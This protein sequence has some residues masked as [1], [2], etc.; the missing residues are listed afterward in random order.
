MRTRPDRRPNRKND[1]KVLMA[2]ESTKS[3]ADTDS[4]SSS[5]SSS[6]SSDSEQEEV[7]CLMADQASDDEN[8]P[9]LNDNGKAG[10]GFS[11]PENS[12]PSWLKNK[13]DK[14]KAKAGRKP[15]VPNQP[16]RSSMKVVSHRFTQ[17][18]VMCSGGTVDNQSREACCVGNIPVAVFLIHSPTTMAS[19][20]ISSS[21]HVDFES[22]FGFDDAMV[23][24]F[25]TLI[26]TG[27]KNFLGCPA[28]FYEAALTEFFTNGSVRDGLVVSTVNGVTVEISE[29]VFA[30]AFELLI[31]G[32]TD[33]SDVPKNLASKTT[34]P[35]LS[36]V[37]A[38]ISPLFDDLKTYLSQRMDTANSDI[39][40]IL[41]TVERGVQDTLGQQNDYFRGLI[42]SARQDAQTQDNIQTLRFNEFCKNILAQNASIFTG[43]ADVRKE[44][45]EINAKVDIMATNLEIVKKDVEASKEALSHQL[46]EF[47]AQAQANH[48]ILHAPLSEI[49]A[50]INRG[51][52]NKKGESSSS[53]GPQPPPPPVDQIRG[54]GANVSIPDFA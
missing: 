7:H 26:T 39:L 38:D 1:R 23:Q 14:D 2:E 15:F 16:W 22:V 25:E 37:P 33:L 50:Y 32:L 40:S 35:T 42:Q 27:L 36:D 28:V 43:L 19:S 34:T 41:H 54:T 30:E 17:L 18:Q 51:G 20:L 53:R 3:W 49:V 31:D 9:K 45:Q 48:N 11:K 52:D 13:L 21:H 8:S 24:M 44:V 29:K 47:Q 4:D 5:S 6:S 10:I 46:L 12:K